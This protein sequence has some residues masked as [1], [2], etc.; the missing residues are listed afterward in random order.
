[1]SDKEKLKRKTDAAIDALKSPRLRWVMGRS[2]VKME[3]DEQK[4][5]KAVDSIMQDENERHMITG[6]LEEKGSLTVE[7]IS[8]LTG[9][10]PRRI[11]QHI[12][13]LRRTGTITETGEKNSQYLYKIA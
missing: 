8:Q 6:A 3:I 4:Y 10:Q 5:Q 1:M 13:A 7:E 2:Q 9:L 12:I 11:V